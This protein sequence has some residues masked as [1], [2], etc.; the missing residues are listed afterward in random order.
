MAPTTVSITSH[1][2][3]SAPRPHILYSINVNN[4]GKEF[5]VPRR[6]SE[7]IALHETLKDSF[8]LPPKRL[9]VTYF[10]PSAWVDDALISER[11]AGLTEYL[12]SLLSSEEYKDSEILAKFLSSEEADFELPNSLR[13]DL[14]D[15]V[16][17]TLSRK[18]ALNLASTRPTAAA[19]AAF[20]EQGSVDAADVSTQAAPLYAAYYPGWASGSNPPEGLNYSKFDVLFYAFVM[21]N[22]SNGVNWDGS[23]S[24]LSRLVNSARK[25]NTGT[26]IVLSVGGWGGSYWFSQ[27]TSNSANRTKFANALMAIV[28]RYNLDG[29]DLDWE[30]PNS[31]GA[32][33]PH[34]PNDA[35]NLL[36]F[37]KLL[38]QQ[39]G[40]SRILSAAVAHMPWLGSNG[41]PLKSVSE[42]A[43]V[44]SFVCIMNYDVWGSSGNPGPNAPMGNLCGTSKQP[45]ASAQGGSAAWK[46]A[47]M[48]ASKQLMGLALYGWVSKSTKTVLTGASVPSSA[49]VLLEKSEAKSKR[50]DGEE[51]ETE[52]FL[53]GAHPRS[54]DGPLAQSAS[55]AEGEVAETVEA[56]AAKDEIKIQADLRGWWGQQIPFKTLV[57]SGALKKRSDGNYGEG[58]GYTMG[59][60]NCSNTPYLFNVGHQTVV[61]YD[62]TWSLNDKAKWS[63][64]NGLAGCFSWSLDQDEGYTLQNVV[65]KALGK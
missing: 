39:M 24:V 49:M 36:S 53:N 50:S 38:R 21:P 41:A 40:P 43:A 25:A 17:S 19:A 61:S 55:V 48:P 32:G 37:M 1:T 9:L 47:G 23:E 3:A 20:A 62:D 29:L 11:K 65:R 64:E 46:A 27:A 22:A 63:R 60:D 2:T 54:K 26:K 44:M 58:G 10:I 28:N 12:N 31:A 56:A 16:P 34:G 52:F 8:K 15:A 4:D 7:F 5:I 14:E 35:A 30:Y 59:W 6:Y 51:P 33:N 42:Y 13:F 45:Q 57:S 18:A